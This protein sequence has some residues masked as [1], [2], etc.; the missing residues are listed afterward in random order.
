MQTYITIMTLLSQVM[1]V[2]D[3]GVG[4]SSLMMAFCDNMFMTNYVA[5]IGVDFKFKQ[6]EFQGKQCKLQVWDTA[7]QERFRYQERLTCQCEC[8]D[9]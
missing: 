8:V 1:L 5:T 9:N 2:G 4:K 3:S 7:G 6:V